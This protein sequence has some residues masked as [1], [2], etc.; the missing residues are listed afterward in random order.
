M[1][2]DDDDDWWWLLL[3]LMNDDQKKYTSL[4]ILVDS[5]GSINS[6]GGYVEWY[7]KNFGNSS[8]VKFS[9]HE[10]T[11]QLIAMKTYWNKSEVNKQIDNDNDAISFIHKCLFTGS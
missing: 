7:A 10:P 1:M 5:G 8:N 11:Q 9:L 6:T 3:S 2:I 4:T